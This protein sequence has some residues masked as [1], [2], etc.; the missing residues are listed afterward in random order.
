[1]IIYKHTILNKHPWI[2]III[3]NTIIIITISHRQNHHHKPDTLNITT[4]TIVI[5]HT[6]Q[7]VILLLTFHAREIGFEVALQ[8]LIARLGVIQYRVGYPHVAS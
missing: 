4:I 6:Y 7:I 5:I 2:I 8:I 1:M 3:T